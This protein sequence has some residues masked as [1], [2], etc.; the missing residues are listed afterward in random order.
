MRKI[1]LKAVD[2][3]D[4][5]LYSVSAIDFK[6]NKI[7]VQFKGNLENVYEFEDIC[8]IQSTEMIDN[9]GN[10]VYESD[11]LSDGVKTFCINYNKS[12]G[13]YCGTEVNSVEEESLEVLLRR[14]FI[15]VG[16]FYTE[17]AR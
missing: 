9:N 7:S 16:N 15:V 2:E 4:K 3:F 14:R 13:L 10:E 8:I 6:K 12:K 1:I 17:K 11:L 5:K